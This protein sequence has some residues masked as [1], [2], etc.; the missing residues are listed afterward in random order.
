MDCKYSADH[1]ER[2]A[3]LE[4]KTEIIPVLVDGLN[5]IKATLRS[6]KWSVYTGVAVVI[7]QQ[8]GWIESLKLFFQ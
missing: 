8:L 5:D 4:Q 7:A 6:L 2:I 3:K 1:I